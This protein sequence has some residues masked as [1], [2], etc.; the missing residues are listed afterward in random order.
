MDSLVWAKIMDF[1][2]NAFPTL[3]WEKKQKRKLQQIM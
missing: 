3:F 2:N 1:D